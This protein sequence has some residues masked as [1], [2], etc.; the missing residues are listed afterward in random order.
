MGQNL[1]SKR[2]NLILCPVSINPVRAPPPL[3][4]AAEML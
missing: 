2:D 1:Y 4:A 3:N